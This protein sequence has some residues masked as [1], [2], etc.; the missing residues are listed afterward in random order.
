MA[1]KVPAVVQFA[2]TSH[3]VIVFGPQ[4]FVLAMSSSHKSLTTTLLPT[5]KT[6]PLSKIILYHAIDNYVYYFHCG[7]YLIF[8]ILSVLKF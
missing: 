1:N 6:N 4:V 5:I 3:L 7:F 8:T 2:Y